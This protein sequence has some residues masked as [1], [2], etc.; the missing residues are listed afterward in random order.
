MLVPRRADFA[1]PVAADPQPRLDELVELP[2]RAAAHT[3]LLAVFQQRLL[4][5]PTRL[6]DAEKVAAMTN[7]RDLQLDLTGPRVP[8]A[9]A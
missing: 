3:D 9:L 6:Q 5:A 2:S 8:A 1:D 4:A 7:L